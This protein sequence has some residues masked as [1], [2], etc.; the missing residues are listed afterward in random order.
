MAKLALRSLEPLK[1]HGVN[2]I[3]DATPLD[4]GR[5]VEIIKEVSEKSGIHIICA[6]GR[7]TELQGKWAYFRQRSANK[8]GDVCM[9]IYEGMVKEINEGIGPSAVKPGVIKVATGHGFI[10]PLE[11]AALRAAAR[12]SRETGVPVIT[13]TENGTM[14]PE[15]AKIL[16]GEGM[17]PKKIMI[18]HM[19]GN[20]SLQYQ[21][22]VLSKG[23][24]I[25]FDRFGIET[26]LPDEVRTSMLIGLLGVGC[27]DRIMMSHDFM[28]CVSGRGGKIP[29]EIGR[30]TARWSL[31]HIFEN[32]IPALKKAGVSDGQIRT[33]TIENPRRLLCGH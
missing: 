29:E 23:V 31:T 14:G 1:A 20:P 9:E 10:S 4:L 5:D 26:F 28:C 22:E 17:D 33:M 7:Y 32:I 8:I 12:A 13:H 21:R 3:I 18:G 2:S 24:N 27:A 30:K 19:C 11:D 25:S 6:T 15:Q 16:T